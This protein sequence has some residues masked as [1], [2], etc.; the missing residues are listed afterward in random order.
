MKKIFS[1]LLVFVFVLSMSGCEQGMQTLEKLEN[2][3]LPPLPTATEEVVTVADGADPAEEPDGDA[4]GT[5][6]TVSQE[7][8]SY[9]TVELANRVLVNIGSTSLEEYDPQ[10]GELLILT[11]SYET[12]HVSI[13]GRNE[14]AQKINNYI[15]MLDE[16]YYTGNDY[17]AGSSLGYNAML[18]FAQDH[19][20]YMVDTGSAY[21]AAVDLFFS[22]RTASITRADAAIL[23]VLYDN[24]NYTGNAQGSQTD[25]AYIFDTQTGERLSLESLSGDKKALSAFL[26]DYMVGLTENDTAYYQRIQLD[27]AKS[28]MGVE[29]LKGACEA[30]LR[31]GSWYFDSDGLVIFSDQ[32][33][34]GSMVAGMIEFHVPY[35]ELSGVIDGKWLPEKK[36][37]AGRF[38][39]APMDDIE[40]GTV[41]IIDF[42]SANHEGETYCITAEGAVY[43]VRISAVQ[44][45]NSFYETALLWYASHMSGCAIQL[46]ALLPDGMPNLMISYTSGG[47]RHSVLL[48]HGEEGGPA[49]VDDTIEAVG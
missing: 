44:Y 26:V 29:D 3:D 38:T 41:E 14:A 45:S 31:E 22:E 25:R 9:E 16:T 15:A 40:D 27:I 37:D 19:Y 18:E 2:I 20:G 23:S 10:N 13:D 30:L 24:Y 42:V 21:D 34:M 35:T 33:E 49:L 11:F 1:L 36:A 12:P 28:I 48:T 8:V 43:D 46:Q 6:A 5:E 39:I 32:G 4:E 47:E 17:G 7:P